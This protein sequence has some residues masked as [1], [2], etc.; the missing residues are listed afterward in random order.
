MKK[1]VKTVICAL[2]AFTMLF[3]VSA[4]S[5]WTPEGGAGPLKSSAQGKAIGLGN[6]NA[7]IEVVVVV[8]G[9]SKAIK[10]QFDEIFSVADVA[11][12]IAMTE[13]RSADKLTVTGNKCELVTIGG[14]Q[15]YK[16]L[17]I[18]D[19]YFMAGDT[20]NLYK[21]IGGDAAITDLSAYCQTEAGIK[22]YY[23][24]FEAV[25][26]K[27]CKEDNTS[28]TQAGDVKLSDVANFNTANKSMRK[29]YSSYWNSQ[30]N[31]IAGSL[32]FN[33]NMD[34][35]ENYLLAY[36]FDKI[37]NIVL[38]KKGDNNTI[39]NIIGGITTGATLSANTKF[40]LNVA[41]AAYDQALANQTNL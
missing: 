2:M 39:Y 27:V 32:G 17:R 11:S 23:D 6:G 28:G 18:G 38:P 8:D 26:L 25:Q 36:G 35:L 1:T 15:Y 29:R 22:W 20:A 9:Y 7:V 37:E 16:Y 40:Y 21:Q 4:C 31:L 30:T 10:V 14:K 19:K 34:M 3:A 13:I 33:G 41:K 24:C 5:E 12:N